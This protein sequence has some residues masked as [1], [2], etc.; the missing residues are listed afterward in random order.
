MLLSAENLTIGYSAQHPV[1]ANLSLTLAKGQL[2]SLLGPNGVGKSTLLR[3]L[4]NLQRPL[5]GSIS[6]NG[7]NIASL[8]AQELSRTIALVLTDRVSAGG[9]TVFELVSLGRQ[10]YTGFFGR[11][12]DADK[13]L[14][15]KAMTDVGIAAKAECHVSELSDGERQKVMIAKALAQETPVIFLDEPTAFLDFPSKVEIMLLLHNL[16]RTTGKTIFLSTH[17]LELALQI[18]DTIWLMD[19]QKGVVIGTPEK[20]ATDGSL[21]NFFTQRGIEFDIHDVNGS[22]CIIP[23]IKKLTSE[24][25]I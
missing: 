18:S 15:I 12:T 23:K 5:S 2:T 21:N 4:A 3:T 6:V 1:A 20:L 7:T 10:P 13:E 8:T 16:S 24:N 9:L 14:V 22:L 25:T 11:L 17:D 19:R